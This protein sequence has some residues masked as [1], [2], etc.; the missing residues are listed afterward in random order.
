MEALKWD[1]PWMQ[2]QHYIPP[3][4]HNALLYRYIITCNAT[5]QHVLTS[6]ALL[7]RGPK[8]GA[9]RVHTQNTISADGQKSVAEWHIKD[10]RGC[11]NQG[12]PEGSGRGPRGSGRGPRGS[13]R[14]QNPGL[15]RYPRRVSSIWRPPK[16]GDG[17][18]P[19]GRKPKGT[20]ALME[21]NALLSI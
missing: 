3:M 14:A 7:L 20:Y 2:P 19:T 1:G 4:H 10:L 9:K 16:Q 6:C 17:Q 21:Q 13:G 15:G 12:V 11:P 5:M 18:R 8:K